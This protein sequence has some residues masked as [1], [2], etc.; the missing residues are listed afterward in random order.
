MKQHTI[1]NPKHEALAATHKNFAVIA[2]K[3][4]NLS[5]GTGV[6]NGLRF[7]MSETIVCS[8]ERHLS[9]GGN[10]P[11]QIEKSVR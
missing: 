4:G 5:S 6:Q 7:V 11:T 3:K 9:V 1:L 10:D 8:A 2:T